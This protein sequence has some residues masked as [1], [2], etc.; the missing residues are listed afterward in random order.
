M[1]SV[2]IL[3]NLFFLTLALFTLG[4]LGSLLF[5]R[6]SKAAHIWSSVF[7]V[8]GSLCALV[9]SLTSLFQNSTLY[10]YS[11]STFPWLRFAFTLDHLSVFF[12]FVISL[13]AIAASFYGYGYAKQYLGK[14]NLGTLGFFYNFFILGMLLVVTSSNILFFLIAWEIMSVASYFLVVYERHEH[15]N[16]KAGSL[17]F[18]MTHVGTA[19]IIVAFLLMFRAT[20]SLEFEQIRL[21]LMN[22]PLWIQNTIF[23]LALVGFGTKAG[24]IPLHIWLPSAHPAAPSHVSALMSGVMIKTGIYM[25]VRIFFDLLGPAQLWWGVLILALGAVSAL[26]GVLYALSEHDLKKLLAYHS[27]ENIGIILL[28]LG[29]S[30]VF[31]SFGMKTL[32]LIGVIAALF[33]TMNHAVF[34]GLLFLGAGSVIH[35]MHTRNIEKYGGLIRY[36]PQTALLFLVGAMAISAL[37]PL[38]GFASEWLTFQTMFSGVSALGSIMSMVFV[39]AIGALAFTGGLAAACFVKAFGITFLARPRTKEVE[40]AKESSPSLLIGMYF[41]AILTLVFG[42]FAGKVTAILSVL[43]SS[44][45]NI[46]AA[47]SDALTVLPG[48]STVHLSNNFASVSLGTVFIGLAIALAL[49]GVI[50]GLATKNRTLR[51]DRTWDCGTEL[52][53]RMEITATGFSRSLIVIFQGLLRPTRQTHIEYHDAELRYFPKKSVVHLELKDIYSAYF[54]YPVQIVIDRVSDKFKNIQSGNINL[55]I[56]YILITL[57]AL[58]VILAH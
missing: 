50:V 43:A 21:A 22:A 14:Y 3:Q 13:V 36:M 55:Y 25:F 8:A 39:L 42:V 32:A 30:L 20:G 29:S 45:Q 6:D 46:G 11:V 18:I 5:Y 52:E 24:I 28:G 37:P 1:L 35:E 19:F 58:L 10:I 38:N 41:L 2:T 56:V 49:I 7:S 9:F 33:H 40:H 15:A 27:I 54:Y 51:R 16:I 53:P 31:L 17:Y 34:K 47:E 44:L 26:L 12:V 4:G 23:V 48:V 57:I